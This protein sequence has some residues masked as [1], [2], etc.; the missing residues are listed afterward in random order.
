MT[1]ITRRAWLALPAAAALAAPLLFGAC[2]TAPTAD[3]TPPIVFV[4]GNGDQAGLWTTQLWHFESN[5]WPRER[6]HAVHFPMPTA[7]QDD[8]KPEPGRSSAAEAR[9]HL[10]AEVQK[11]LAATG[12]KRVVLVANSRGGLTVRDYIRN[13]G[14]D[15]TV[16]HAVLGGT[17]NHGVWNV[18][19]FLPNSIFNGSS[20]FLKALNAPQGPD[21]AEVTPG[22]KWLTLRSDGNDK[23]AQPDGVWIGARGTPTNITAVGPELKGA[24]NTVLPGLDHREVSYHPK[25]FA[26]TYAFVTGQAPATTA[27]TPEAQVTL[28]G[29]VSGLGAGGYDNLPLAG[30]RVEVYAVQAGTGARQGAAL[31]DKVVGAD[32][33]WG[34]V[35]TTPTTPL[36]FVISAPGH[37][38]TH[39][40]R[41]PFPRSSSIVT[42][43]AERLADADKTAMSVVSFTRPRGYFGLPRDTIVFDGVQP[44]PGI[45]P[46]VAGVASSKL[47]LQVGAGRPVA[48]EFRSGELAERVVGVAWP[49]RDNHVVT[50]E[51]HR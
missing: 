39:I 34:P 16:S 3:A 29:Q 32:G 26:A 27:I 20:P 43:R 6:L 35:R 38:V 12:A 24:T 18:P 25:A 22:V 45:P 10:A 23:F 50:L 47:K 49:A 4:H 13:G 21:G 44:A 31:A 2:A 33:R 48:A 5:G 8:G 30:A 40:Y 1:R 14:G 42:L 9:D 11:V 15:K 41:S 28:E 51:L 46:G 37:A 17:P 36:E 7:R 19:A